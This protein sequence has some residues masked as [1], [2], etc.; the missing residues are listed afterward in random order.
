MS[1]VIKFPGPDI[2]VLDI[3]D[4]VPLTDFIEV[5]H[6]RQQLDAAGIDDLTAVDRFIETNGT[7]AFIVGDEYDDAD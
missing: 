6:N 7:N 1:N 5:S 2:D 4:N 3:P